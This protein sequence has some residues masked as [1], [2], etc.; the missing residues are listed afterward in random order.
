MRRL[1]ARPQPAGP[2]ADNEPVGQAQSQLAAPP[3]RLTSAG[4][5]TAGHLTTPFED[6]WV[7]PDLST[8]RSQAGTSV[9]GRRI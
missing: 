6:L 7:I 1:A 9:R 8:R 4:A 5:R 2:S 3:P